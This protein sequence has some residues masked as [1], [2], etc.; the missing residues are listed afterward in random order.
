M[1]AWLKRAWA[2][3]VGLLKR[4]PHD[5]V[6]IVVDDVPDAVRARHLYLVGDSGSTWAAAFLCPCGCGEVIQLSLMPDDRPRWT[7]TLH[8][9]KT[10]TL[11]P[12]VWRVRGCKS[13]F[14][15]RQSMVEW[16][17]GQGSTR[18]AS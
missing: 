3:V 13:H 7:L 18:S 12:S 1:R 5:L 4:Q 11:Y 15:V 6:P 16:C 8:D 9:D 17:G 2:S 10:V 14:F